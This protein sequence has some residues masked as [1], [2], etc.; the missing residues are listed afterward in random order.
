LYY[1]SIL[2]FRHHNIL[3][4]YFSLHPLDSSC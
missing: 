4:F 1:N 3:L 2:C